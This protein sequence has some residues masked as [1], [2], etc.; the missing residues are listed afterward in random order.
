MTP[1]LQRMISLANETVCIYADLLY[2]YANTNEIYELIEAHREAVNEL[3]ELQG[4]TD[5][6]DLGTETQPW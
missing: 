4:L 6:D 5:Q 1:Q 3:R 2:L